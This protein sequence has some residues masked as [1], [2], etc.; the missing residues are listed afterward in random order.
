MSLTFARNAALALLIC[1]GYG[2]LLGSLPD[3]VQCHTTNGVEVCQ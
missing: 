3:A 2:V 1:L